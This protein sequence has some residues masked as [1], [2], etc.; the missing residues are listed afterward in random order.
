MKKFSKLLLVT[1]AVVLLAST[2]FSTLS[3]A[4]YDSEF[5]DA[6]ILEADSFGS[7]KVEDF[8]NEDI[9]MKQYLS[10]G[11][12]Y[13]ESASENTLAEK[14]ITFPTATKYGIFSTA[15][16]KTGN[17]YAKLTYEQAFALE[18]GSTSYQSYIQIDDK[19]AF[20]NN[21]YLIY[22]WD[23]TTET[24]YPADFAAFF[25]NS[26]NTSNG[27]KI[28]LFAGNSTGDKIVVGDAEYDLGDVGT[29][30][31]ITVVIKLVSSSTSGYMDSLGLIFLNGEKV[32]E[33]TPVETSKRKYSLRLWIGYYDQARNE[34]VDGSTVCI[35]NFVS[36]TVSTGYADTD[37][38]NLAPLFAETP[39]TD[40]AE[41]SGNE[42]V[43]GAD[44][45]VPCEPEIGVRAE[46]G[47]IQYYDTFEEAYT[48]YKAGA[49]KWIELY[50][51]QEG[52]IDAPVVLALYG[53]ATFTDTS[54]AAEDEKYPCVSAQSGDIVYHTYTK[55]TE[56]KLTVQFFNAMKGTDAAAEPV[57]VETFG[58]GTIPVVPE[59]L[60]AVEFSPNFDNPEKVYQV[61]DAFVYFLGEDEQENSPLVTE[62]L[63]A[64]DGVVCQVYP[65]YKEQAL[66]F[67]MLVVENEVSLTKYF[68]DPTLFED[69]VNDA[70]D[71]AV[72]ILRR[73][74]GI[75][76]KIDVKEKT[77]SIDLAGKNLY[78]SGEVAVTPFG[79]ESGTLYV[80]S[81]APG[82]NIYCGKDT[83][84]AILATVT[85]GSGATLHIGYADEE[86][87]DAYKGNLTVHT[88][89][90]AK[91]SAKDTLINVY[92]TDV[93]VVNTNNT[94]LGVLEFSSNK[95]E[96]AVVT[97]SGVNVYNTY[98]QNNI[99]AFVSVGDSNTVNLVDTNIY[100]TGD[101]AAFIYSPEGSEPLNASLQTINLNGVAY[102]GTLK[103]IAF[104]NEQKYAL[105]VGGKVEANALDTET[106][107]YGEDAMFIQNNRLDNLSIGYTPAGVY[108]A[109]AVAQE[110]E[111]PA[112]KTY[113]N[114]GVSREDFCNVKWYFNDDAA[115]E[116][117][118]V[119]GVTPE[120]RGEYPVSSEHITYTHEGMTI[121]PIAEGVSEVTVNSIEVAK[122][123]LLNLSQNV[124]IMLGMR[125]NLYIPTT[126]PAI[127]VTVGETTVLVNNE[128]TTEDGK[129]HIVEIGEFNL[130]DLSTVEFTF[131]VN[132]KTV[133]ETELTVE[134]T[135]VI[136]DY[137][138]SVYEDE[139][140]EEVERRL[141]TAF[142]KYAQSAGSYLGVDTTAIGELIAGKVANYYLIEGL[143]DTGVVRSAIKGVRM[144]LVEVPQFVFYLRETYNGTLTVGGKEY[145]VVD[146]KVNDVAYILYTPNSYVE[147]GDG[148]A[149]SVNGTVVDTAVEGSGA[150]SLTNYLM[151]VR[152]ELG[153]TPS[154]VLDLYQF[155]AAAKVFSE[156]E[157][158]SGNEEY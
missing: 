111:L 157:S 7:R 73:S 81:S 154:Y 149:I 125:Y 101:D 134:S 12:A 118:W 142:L 144:N 20:A 86:A 44:Y 137:F 69:T 22:E 27:D 50:K 26:N 60:V 129:Y 40:L 38:D 16:S 24:Q 47:S 36:T 96:N 85:S 102:Y 31:H 70:P 28:P 119:H 155:Y 122:I 4:Q 123:E 8:S 127:S 68:I 74:L 56:K 1:L 94:A 106:L 77:L 14:W 53:G 67:E 5:E 11:V 65:V 49:Q 91:V 132:L 136:L 71:G 130:R 58:V 39:V 64:G 79:V 128:L 108:G 133:R 35:D 6:L 124:A 61:T 90:V 23:M 109:P 46:D 29:W 89:T 138:A 99:L 100:I 151:G 116:E 2:V 131:T 21:D 98:A 17:R 19:Q 152:E 153:S 76:S 117:L 147:L 15:D 45:E 57:L 54:T 30:N 93:K 105:T 25:V 140:L 103:G 141:T 114:I 107:I 41:L 126:V 34:T 83:V 87:A 150:F 120:F 48:A 115:P 78:Q 66:A 51:S 143:E 10:P 63:L 145:T 62:A 18:E 80:Y 158:D 88:P 110:L 97:F 112:L 84:S 156:Y 92:G 146:G 148:I 3:T 55:E 9:L 52:V 13:A 32:G 33:F 43:W 75:A 37:A 104:T 121:E 59:E 72:V 82:A 113:V 139:T 95:C 42:I 135:A